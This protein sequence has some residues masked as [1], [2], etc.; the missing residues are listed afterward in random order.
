MDPRLEPMD[1]FVPFLALLLTA[2]LMRRIALRRWQA[3][4]RPAKVTIQ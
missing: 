3:G 4:G 1:S 2:V